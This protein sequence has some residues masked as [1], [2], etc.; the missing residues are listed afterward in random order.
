L[1]QPH[2]E[3]SQRLAA[4]VQTV[5]AKDGLHK[6]IGNAKLA[7]VVLAIVILWLSLKDEVISTNW[8]AFPVVIY[9][10]LAVAHEFALR[11][12]APPPPP[13]AV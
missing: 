5:T 6:Q 1:P 12:G 9:A 4:R 8:L 3:Y 11:G 7:V 13:G 10:G 2:A